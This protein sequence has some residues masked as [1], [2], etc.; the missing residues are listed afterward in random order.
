MR[1]SDILIT[2]GILLVICVLAVPVIT[3]F[4]AYFLPRVYTSEVIMELKP[5]A[6]LPMDPPVD[7]GATSANFIPDQIQILESKGILYPV[8]DGLGLVDRWS[9]GLPTKLT[10]EGTY[11]LLLNM[12][13]VFRKRDTNF[14]I[15]AATSTD[16]QEASDI[17]NTIAIIYQKN[18]RDARQK[19]INNALAEMND[20]L[21][22]QRQ[23]TQAA[24]A[25]LDSI[26]ARDNIQDANPDNADKPVTPSNPGYEAAKAKYLDAKKL[27]DAG[28]Q[29]YESDKMDMQIEY[30]PAQ[31]WNRAEP[32]PYPSGPNVPRIMEAATLAGFACAPCGIV[33]III[34][35]QCKRHEADS[36]AA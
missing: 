18:L 1:K 33:F 17:A 15:V 36:P 10:R 24:K 8:I 30:V 29:K 25:A 28:V 7:S 3:Y 14:V 27:L 31:I 21:E 11:D 6:P 32:A 23:N 35:L 20:E 22:R 34:G 16:K 26:R 19:K 2:L 12:T 5:A 4:W 9:A 13:R